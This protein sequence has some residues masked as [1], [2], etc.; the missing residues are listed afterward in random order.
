[1]LKSEVRE[2]VELLQ[3]FLAWE[4]SPCMKKEMEAAICFYEKKAGF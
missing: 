2:I 3:H 4:V 1:M